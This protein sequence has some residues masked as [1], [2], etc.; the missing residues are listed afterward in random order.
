MGKAEKEELF[1]WL[2]PRKLAL[3]GIVGVL[4]CTSVEIDKHFQVS[5]SQQILSKTEQNDACFNR[6]NIL[7]C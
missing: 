2:G 1:F 3:D 6:T 7:A 5:S 4:S